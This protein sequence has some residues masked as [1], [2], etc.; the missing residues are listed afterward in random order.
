VPDLVHAV[1]FFQATYTILLALALGEAFKQFVPDGDQNIR[2]DRFPSLVAFLFTIFPFFQGMS[3]YMYA[4]YLHQPGLT[5]SA[6]SVQLFFDSIMF[7]LMA[8]TFFVLSRS[9]SPNHWL[10]YYVATLVLLAVDTVWILA[11]NYHGAG[12]QV[13]LI[14]NILVVSILASVITRQ[15][16]EEFDNKQ[17]PGLTSPPWICACLLIVSTTIDYVWFWDYFFPK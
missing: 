8:G 6:V 2:W 15:R 7:L 11:S 13:W 9:L 16:G 10:R 14:L 12:L 1:Q 3:Q 4:T 17:I 5:L